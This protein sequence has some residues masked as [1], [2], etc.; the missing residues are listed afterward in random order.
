MIDPAS[1]LCDGCLRTLDEIARWA[2]MTAGQKWDVMDRV[3]ERRVQRA[4]GGHAG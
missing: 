2:E 4:E 3:E 1:R